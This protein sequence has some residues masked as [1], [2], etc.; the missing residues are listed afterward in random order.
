MCSTGMAPPPPQRHCN[1]IWMFYQ[2]FLSFFWGLSTAAMQ[3]CSHSLVPKEITFGVEIIH[4][5]EIKLS[6]LDEILL[7]EK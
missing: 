3:T 1:T 6:E 5:R 4:N 7:S 2:N